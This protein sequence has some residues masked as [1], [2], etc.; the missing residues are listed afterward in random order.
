MKA[1]KRG[2]RLLPWAVHPKDLQFPHAPAVGTNSPAPKAKA[3]VFFSSR[4]Q[5]Q[6]PSRTHCPHCPPG[7]APRLPWDSQDAG[8]A[9]GG[10][11][12]TGSPGGDLA[13]VG[14][15]PVAPLLSTDRDSTQAKC[16]DFQKILCGNRPTMDTL[17]LLSALSSVQSEWI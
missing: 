2:S 16:T 1:A 3:R 4:I 17:G 9:T 14:F 15:C 6:S 13:L 8:W 12:L 7:S 11:V 10:R 5:N